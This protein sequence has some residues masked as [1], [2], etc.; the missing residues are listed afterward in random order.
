MLAFELKELVLGII[1]GDTRSMARALS[2]AQKNGDEAADRLL[3]QIYPY[4]GNS[5]IIGITGATG[6][7]KSSLIFQA[8]KVLRKRNRSVGVISIDPTS[9]VSGGAFLGD[10]LRM[11][12]LALDSGVF[13]RSVAGGRDSVDSLTKKIFT[14]VHVMEASSK[15]YIFIETIGSGQ[16]D[17]L[18]SKV[19][20][21]TV[22]VSIPTLGD[23]IQAM[24]AG[25][26]E[27]TDIAIVNKADD[28]NRDKAV[29]WWKN[30]LALEEK[31]PGAWKIPVIATD[32]HA[33]EGAE[34]FITAI[35][36]HERH[37][38][39]SGEWERR[40]QETIRE[41]VRMTLKSK[42]LKTLDATRISDKDMGALL[43]RRLDPIVYTAKLLKKRR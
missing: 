16:N 18:I 22:Y 36:D 23:E 37:M 4:G 25:I 26:L 40:K 9:P 12:E 7:G 38:K 3:Q 2:L 6:V 29:T 42:L 28:P 8:A 11:Q 1:S 21:T 31:K 17:C 10:R 30:V 24:K 43:E 39:D 34:T 15:H 5:R 33:G 19:A 32:S 14:L 27:L 41:E 13:I 20:Q 35:D